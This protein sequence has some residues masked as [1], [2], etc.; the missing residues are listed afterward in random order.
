MITVRGTT[1]LSKTWPA[2][3]SILKGQGEEEGQT[4]LA[5]QVCVITVC[6]CGLVAMLG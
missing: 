2:C 4:P 3:K 1:S 5:F 6:T